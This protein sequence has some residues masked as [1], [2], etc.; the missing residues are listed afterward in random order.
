MRPQEDV[1]QPAHSGC[2]PL[3]ALR[4]RWR[5]RSLSRQLASPRLPP[6]FEKVRTYA[7]KCAGRGR[8]HNA[9]HL[10]GPSTTNRVAHLEK[11]ACLPLLCR[12]LWFL[13]LILPSGVWSPPL[14]S[15]AGREVLPEADQH[16][17]PTVRSAALQ[18]RPHHS[19][20]LR[21]RSLP[22]LGL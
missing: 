3:L 22:T 17:P 21:I 6:A 9:S 19:F 18:A 1:A 14:W 13:S 20:Q 16:V 2:L 11:E 8:W 4:C 5:V 15:W 10:Q 7:V 12:G